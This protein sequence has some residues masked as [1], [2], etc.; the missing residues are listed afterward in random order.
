MD[1]RLFGVGE[2]PRSGNR[3]L[4]VGDPGRFVGV[5]GGIALAGLAAAGFGDGDFAAFRAL[6]DARLFFSCQHFSRHKIIRSLVF[7]SLKPKFAII[8][9]S[10]VV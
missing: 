6:D 5:R 2:R 3:S 9:F 8:D 4:L 7:R 10:F 1:V